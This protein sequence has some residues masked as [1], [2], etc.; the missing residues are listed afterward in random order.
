MRVRVRLQVRR[1]LRRLRRRL[2]PA[3]GVVWD[4]DAGVETEEWAEPLDLTVPSG[5]AAEGHTYL[6]T[7]PRLARACLDALCEQRLPD[8]TF[9]D[10][11]SGRG[12]VLLMAAERP[13]RRVIGIEFAQELHQAALANIQ[14]F[15]V[16]RLR[17]TDLTSLLGDAAAYEPP[18]GP[19]VVYF[20]NPFSHTVMSRVVG[21]V[22]AS[23]AQS[24]RPMVLVYQQLVHESARTATDNLSLLEQ[25]SFLT[26][27][28][29]RYRWRDRP[30]LSPFVV[31]LHTTPEAQG[32]TT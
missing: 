30:F 24:P 4:R 13:F 25:Q 22:A 31:R 21:N 1:H 6:P 17:C 28:T 2:A 8:A 16:S 11:G 14:R 15:P 12:R 23:Y 9:V 7:Q 18:A 5:A 32:W 19:L 3:E 20:D 10:V 26:G 27:R 29:L